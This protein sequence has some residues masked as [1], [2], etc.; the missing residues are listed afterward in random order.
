M[1]V[2]DQFGC[3][4][5]HILVNIVLG[6]GWGGGVTLDSLAAYFAQS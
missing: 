3:L 1:V 2:V 4:F 5:S 6:V